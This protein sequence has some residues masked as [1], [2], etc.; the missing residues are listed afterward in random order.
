MIALLPV[1][2]V[3]PSDENLPEGVEHAKANGQ[4]QERPAENEPGRTTRFY[5]CDGRGG[6]VEQ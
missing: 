1:D 4:W 2:V 5:V 6:T 3:E